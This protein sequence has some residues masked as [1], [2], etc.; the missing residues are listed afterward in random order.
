MI[1]IYF[2]V[3]HFFCLFK[4][5]KYRIPKNKIRNMMKNKN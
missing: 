3:S 5:Y 1:F 4:I 2:K